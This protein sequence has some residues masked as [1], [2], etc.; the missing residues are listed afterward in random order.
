M[1]RL[2]VKYLPGRKN[3]ADFLSR[4]PSLRA[5]PDS[6]DEDLVDEVEIAVI[7]AVEEITYESCL[8]LNENDIQ[9]AA[10]ED[11]AYQMLVAKVQNGDWHAQ[12]P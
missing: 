2:Q 7:A 5:S 12:R 3:T 6:S 10:S 1:Y 4:Y 8:T 9:E 11:P